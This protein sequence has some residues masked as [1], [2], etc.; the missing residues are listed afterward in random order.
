MGRKL[1]SIQRIN[2][3]EPIP[4]AD[5]IEV[6]TV[7]GWKV[8]VKKNEFKIG[9]LCVFFEIDSFLPEKPE[10]E[11]LRPSSAMTLVTGENGFRL[12]TVKLR[13]QVSQGLALPVN[14][15]TYGLD[16]GTDVTDVLG[17]LLYERFIQD[18][19]HIKSTFPH[20]IKKTD[21]TRLQGLSREFSAYKELTWDIT[22]KIN[23]QSLT[24]Y[25]RNDDV[26]VCTRNME[27]ER[28]DTYIWRC[29][30]DSAIEDKLRRLKLNIA[31]QGE[32][33]GA[34]IQGNP[35]N[36]PLDLRL[37]RVFDID[38]QRMIAQPEFLQLSA[39]LRLKTVP[40]LGSIR[41]PDTMQEAIKLADG[42]SVLNNS[43][44]REGIVAVNSDDPDNRLSFKI[45]SNAYLLKQKD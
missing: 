11:F 35:Y 18:T 29:V 7:L 34:G 15:I 22:E 39:E 37:F 2:N 3:I 38:A 4:D 13:K 43:V 30:D 23:G 1:A 28:S 17:V 42:F 6:A 45:I 27:L 40:L 5:A 33:H 16:E 14:E 9:D 10:Y 31:I 24:I 26:G 44:R 21:E 20:F 19:T 25:F 12:K 8:V 32:L 41:L 36:I